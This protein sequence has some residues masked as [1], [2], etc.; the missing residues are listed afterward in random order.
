MTSVKKI[1]ITGASSGVGRSLANLFYKKGF[2]LILVSRRT[3]YVQEDFFNSKHVYAYSADFQNAEDAQN[4]IDQIF[5]DHP[6]VP[7]IVNNA[8]ILVQGRLDTLAT[9]DI[10]RSL[11]VN[12]RI[13]LYIMTKAVKAMAEK[14]FGRIV[15]ITSGAPLNCFPGVGAYSA[16]K[17]MLNALTV[18]FAREY[19]HHNIKVNLMSPGPV[20]SEMS[21]NAELLPE[22]C[23]PTLEYLLN[24]TESGDTGK[25]YWLG[26]EVPLFPDLEGVQ[27]LKGIGNEKL[28]RI[29]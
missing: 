23:H 12:A 7:Y 19:K 6:Y 15:N 1:L 4:V 16:S 3:S 18:T 27:W 29:L 25:F 22:I 14:G 9:N 5:I 10:E 28:K 24:S 13:P 17:A 21:P 8:G 26:Y 11:N 2:E 20:K